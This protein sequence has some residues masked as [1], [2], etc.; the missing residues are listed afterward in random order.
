MQIQLYY[1]YKQ[2]FLGH[3]VE[4]FSF[5][6][7]VC[8]YTHTFTHACTCIHPYIYTHG[9]IIT[10]H[11]LHVKKSHS[12]C[13]QSLIK[14]HPNRLLCCLLLHRVFVCF[15]FLFYAIQNSYLSLHSNSPFPLSRKSAVI[16]RRSARNY[17]NK[18]YIA[19]KRMLSTVKSYLNYLMLQTVEELW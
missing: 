5:R 18:P 4:Q 17:R 6:R 10:M 16:C 3:W 13:S 7:L 9:L 12:D 11:T 2:V 19:K 1:I 15:V 14:Y 8:S